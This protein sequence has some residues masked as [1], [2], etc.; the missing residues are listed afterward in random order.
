MKV[1]LDTAATRKAMAVVKPA[2]GRG[3]LPVLSGVRIDTKADGATMF[4][5]SDLDVTV[6][7]MIPGE[8]AEV[9]SV[10]VSAKAF[11][12]LLTGR[13]GDVT[14]SLE[15]ETLHVTTSMGVSAALPVIPLD[16][17]PALVRCDDAALSLELDVIADVL[18][19]ASKDAARPIFAGILWDGRALVA[20]D[21]YRL[22]LIEQAAK[23]A[24]PWKVLL[25]ARGLRIALKAAGKG[26]KV[27]VVRFD[28][29]GSTAWKYA[30]LEVGAGTSVTMRLI[31][32]EFPNFWRLIPSKWAAGWSVDRAEM[33]AAV[34]AVTLKRS[35][36]HRDPL[37][38]RLTVNDGRMILRSRVQHGPEVEVAIP[39]DAEGDPIGTVN[40]Q[41]K[42]LA[43]AFTAGPLGGETVTL[44]LNDP[45]KPAGI[46]EKIGGWMRT[47]LI[48][49]V[50]IA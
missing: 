8:V 20:T 5:A 36:G 19:A 40:F 16:D 12:D 39:V 30:E 45:L 29:P 15:G 34:K 22:H 27:G 9:G 25:P 43:D 7:T 37:P 1:T 2:L 6:R 33:L 38:I 23:K 26:V 42:F 4:T 17:W 3:H 49:P 31:D 24:E 18:P 47:R 44:R 41:P 11:G 32:G 50:R 35:A 46:V 21:S 14:L 28:C 13:K 10:I 48:M